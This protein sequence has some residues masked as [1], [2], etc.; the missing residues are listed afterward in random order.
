[1]KWTDFRELAP[2]ERR[3]LQKKSGVYRRALDRWVREAKKQ[4]RLS[5][6]FDSQRDTFL[7]QVVPHLIEMHLAGA[8]DEWENFLTRSVPHPS[9]KGIQPTSPQILVTA[10]KQYPHFM[11]GF[12]NDKRKFIPGVLSALADDSWTDVLEETLTT[13]P[14]SG[15]T[16]DEVV[17]ICAERGQMTSNETVRKRVDDWD[18][19]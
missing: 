12:W 9:F 4:S 10:I 17:A 19:T 3:R 16:V 2:L 14:L 15:L 18:R 6:Y 13:E 8:G 7:D 5:Q 11:L 1:M